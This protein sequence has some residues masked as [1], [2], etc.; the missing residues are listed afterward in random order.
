MDSWPDLYRG[1]EAFY[2][3]PPVEFSYDFLHCPV[4]NSLSRGGLNGTIEETIGGQ[5]TRYKIAYAAAERRIESC[6]ICHLLYNIVRS[7]AHK[8]SD[9]QNIKISAL[10]GLKKHEITIY[11]QGSSHVNQLRVKL[12]YAQPRK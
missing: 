5:F 6:Y 9:L 1:S 12:Y 8:L 11:D 10:E 7:Y 2:P 4:C 3:Y